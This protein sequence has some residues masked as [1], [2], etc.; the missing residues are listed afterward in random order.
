MENHEIIR[1]MIKSENELINQRMAWVSSFNGFLLAGIAFAWDKSR[2]LVIVL[3]FL[4]ITVSL[5][6]GAALL[7]ANRAFRELYVW[8][9]E[10]KP[11]NYKGPDV[12]GLSP[13]YKRWP[14]RWLNPWSVIPIFFACAWVIIAIIR[15]TS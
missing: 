9:Q 13:R 1:S 3:A 4:G 5:F 6:S 2:A 11:D 15:L 14:G 8:W 10:N 12:I 7:A